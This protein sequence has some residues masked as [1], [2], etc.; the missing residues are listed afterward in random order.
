MSFSACMYHYSQALVYSTSP[1]LFKATFKIPGPS[2]ASQ[3]VL[4]WKPNGHTHMTIDASLPP[5]HTAT[6]S[7]TCVDMI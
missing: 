7:Q 3:I 1:Y 6:I 4:D 5:P 2:L